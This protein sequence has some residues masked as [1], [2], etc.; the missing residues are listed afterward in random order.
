MYPLHEDRHS[1][2]QLSAGILTLP[3]SI[4]HAQ[5]TRLM[6]WHCRFE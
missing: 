3:S 5:P 1:P 6:A 4:A 2:S